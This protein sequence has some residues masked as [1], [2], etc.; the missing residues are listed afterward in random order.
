VITHQSV[1]ELRHK[2]HAPALHSRV[3]QVLRPGGLYLVCDHFAGE[4][5]MGNTALYMS[6]DEQREALQGAGFVAIEAL[7]VHQG[8]ALHAARR[9]VLS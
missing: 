5:G 6:L 2:R 9:A 1:H 8:L 4:G 7:W 3:L